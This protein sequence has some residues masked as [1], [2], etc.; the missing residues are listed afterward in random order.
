LEVHEGHLIYLKP[1]E[2]QYVT[3]ALVRG[4][5]LTGTGEEIIARLKALEAVGLKQIVLQVVNDGRAMIE[6]FSREV[7][8]KY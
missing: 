4:F 8:A 2:E 1:G 5:S 7:I 3:E 6:E